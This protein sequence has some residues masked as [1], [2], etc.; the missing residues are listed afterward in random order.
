MKHLAKIITGSNNA[1]DDIL[2]AAHIEDTG[3]I[4]IGRLGVPAVKEFFLE[5][6]LCQVLQLL[7]GVAVWIVWFWI[8]YVLDSD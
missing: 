8:D 6:S 2:Q 5:Y 1:I 7:G 4:I 3:I